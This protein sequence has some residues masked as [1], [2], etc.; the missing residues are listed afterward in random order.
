VLKL[1]HLQRGGSFKLRGAVNAL[2]SGERPAH[3]IAASGGNHV[4]GV[5]TASALLGLPVT[6]YVP[7]RVPAGKARR[8]EATGRR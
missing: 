7:D 1:E 3:V 2:V 8:I 6:V 4:L 5:A